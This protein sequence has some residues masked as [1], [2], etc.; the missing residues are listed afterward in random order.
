MAR[1]TVH[2]AQMPKQGQAQAQAR[3]SSGPDC[4]AQWDGL[5]LFR[6]ERNERPLLR[7]LNTIECSEIS[8]FFIY[9]MSL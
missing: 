4:V 7:A 3:P 1:C 8:I 2:G 5:A 9:Y 6:R